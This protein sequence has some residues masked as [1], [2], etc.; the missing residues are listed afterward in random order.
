MKYVVG[1]F[2]SLIALQ[3]CATAPRMVAV[4]NV[5]TYDVARDGAATVDV[6]RQAPNEMLEETQIISCTVKN[7]MDVDRPLFNRVE[8]EVVLDNQVTVS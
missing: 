1:I 2:D 3:G 4:E 8:N 5:R 7:P 6:I